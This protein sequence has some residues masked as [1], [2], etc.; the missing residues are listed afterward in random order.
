MS[1]TRSAALD[2]VKVL[3]LCQVGAGPYCSTML[4]DFGAEVVKV[5]PLGGEPTRSVDNFFA[6]KE[7]A[8]YFGINRSKK[9]IAV[10]IKSEAGHAVLLRLVKW[11]DVV[12]VSMRPPTVA[13]LGLSYEGLVAVNPRIV[14]LSITA[15]GE[16]GPRTE[17]PGMDIVAQALSGVMALTGEPDQ[18]PVKCGASIADWTTSFLGAF[19]ITAALR[20]R[21]RDGV[22]QKLSVSLL[23]G[24][25]ACLPQF[26]SSYMATGTPP[27]RSGSGHPMV[28]PYQVFLT[29]DGNVIVACL[30]DRFWPRLCNA[31]ERP[32]LIT[33][34]RFATNSERVKHRAEI[35]GIIQAILAAKPT[36]E[37][38]D[39][40]EKLSVPHA[41]VL[42]LEEVVVDPQIVHNEMIL[43][44]EHPRFG[45][46]QVVNNPIRM[47]AT[48][49]KPHG[50][51]PGVGEH[52]DEVL[53]GI[54]YTADELASMRTESVIE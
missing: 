47:S 43:T 1:Q 39:R 41:P 12:T 42:E 34:E 17:A 18:P 7:S 27:R 36:A 38:V 2:G 14:Y 16:T 53:L 35:V 48:P 40:F 11:A 30:D 29:A 26:V 13:R 49:P 50:Y 54:G 10:D 45:Q 21:D 51:S 33:D 25:I 3:D 20:A 52:T 23:D 37:W 46:Y 19:A 44:L 5:E 31:L 32:D 9:A 22:G 6:P 4:G 24:A 28:V 8:Y 15:F